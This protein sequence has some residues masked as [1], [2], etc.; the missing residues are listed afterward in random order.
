MVSTIEIAGLHFWDREKL[1]LASEIFT[2]LQEDSP[3]MAEETI[4]MIVGMLKRIFYNILK[5]LA[6]TEERVRNKLVENKARM[7]YGRQQL[8]YRKET[9]SSTACQWLEAL[10][11]ASKYLLE[12]LT[13]LHRLADNFSKVQHLLSPKIDFTQIGFELE[14]FM[15]F[16]I[17]NVTFQTEIEKISFRAQVMRFSL[18]MANQYLDFASDLEFDMGLQEY[19]GNEMTS[20]VY[21]RNTFE[22]LATSSEFECKKS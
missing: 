17:E 13:E 1:N 16:D 9:G 6:E 11:K 15:G 3:S 14:N 5:Q 2:G 20:L 12:A 8:V 10:R 18:N 4:E 21:A 19:R 22:M 7:K